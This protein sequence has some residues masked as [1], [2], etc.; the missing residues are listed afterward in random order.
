MTRQEFSKTIADY[1][2][3]R[4][5]A[6]KTMCFALNCFP[7]NIHIIE[8]GTHSYNLQRCLK[9]LDVVGLSLTISGV[10]ISDYDS[11]V[12]HIVGLRHKNRYSKRALSIAAG[13][14]DF[15]VSL[16]ERKKSTIAIDTL[17]KF[18][19]ILNFTVGVV[20]KQTN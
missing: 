19:G 13:H 20:P 5:I 18:A 6:T 12:S 16:L 9:Y 14:S 15:M 2:R 3:S 10:E 7:A 11:L 17:L 1:R 8:A 4:N